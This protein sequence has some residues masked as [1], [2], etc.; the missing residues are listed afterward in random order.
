MEVI[1]ATSRK[2]LS[3]EGVCLFSFSPSSWN[4]DV[5]ARAREQPFWPQWKTLVE[6][7][8]ALRLKYLHLYK[9][10]INL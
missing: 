5:M 6:M 9:R 8:R 10:E 4:A 2:C 3:K 7:S 1:C